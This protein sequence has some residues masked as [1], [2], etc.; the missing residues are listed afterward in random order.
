MNELKQQYNNL[1]ARYN[2]AESY[3]DSK[4]RTPEEV[5]KWLPEFC[6][7]VKQLCALLNKIGEHTAD[8]AVH[9]FKEANNENT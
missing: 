5:E 9:G 3:I 2:G 4:E 1:L 6:R 8:E 7:I